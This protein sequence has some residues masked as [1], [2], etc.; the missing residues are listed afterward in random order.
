MGLLQEARNK[1][2]A[3]I[4]A[5]QERRQLR[6]AD[7]RML[8]EDV[9]RAGNRIDE[10]FHRYV[11][12]LT[13]G[14]H[15]NIPRVEMAAMAM[16]FLVLQGGYDSIHQDRGMARL[17]DSFDEPYDKV[18]SLLINQIEED[19]RGGR[20]DPM[21]LSNI[22]SIPSSVGKRSNLGR[23]LSNAGY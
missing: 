15:P 5:I 23:R 12:I 7:L 14:K 16:R 10:V 13:D 22:Y 11:E 19:F 2:M 4:K 3:P 20:V 17:R 18:A 8:R 21:R 1:L 6:E 9:Q